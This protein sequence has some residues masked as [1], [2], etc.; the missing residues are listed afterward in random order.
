[1]GDLEDRI[2]EIKQSRDSDLGEL[3]AQ[4]DSI[5]NRLNE[6]R[7]SMTEEIM[8][9]AQ[10]LQRRIESMKGQTLNTPLI[11]E[12]AGEMVADAN[13]TVTNDLLS[14][15]QE[16]VTNRLSDV[17][18]DIEERRKQDLDKLD[19]QADERSAAAAEKIEALQGERD[20]RV[21]RARA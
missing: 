15:V 4:I 8:R 19:L 7:D 3:Q 5:H 10:N 18:L 14:R 6:E 20:V 21:S 1:D 9:E 16:V 12:S 2:L 11:F 17:Q 13:E